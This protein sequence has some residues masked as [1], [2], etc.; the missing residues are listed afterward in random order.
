MP[1]QQLGAKR[2]PTRLDTLLHRRRG[3]QWRATTS[4]LALDMDVVHGAPKGKSFKHMLEPY[5]VRI[6]IPFLL[7]ITTPNPSTAGPP[8]FSSLTRAPP[9]EAGNLVDVVGR[10]QTAPPPLVDLLSFSS[11][12]WS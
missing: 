7:D 11:H 8:S 1:G 6:H 9:R 3:T 10:M 2:L 5:R 12:H 4:S